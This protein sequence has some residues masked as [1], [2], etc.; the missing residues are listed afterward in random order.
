V[1]EQ[2]ALACDLACET[3]GAFGMSR[4]PWSRCCFHCTRPARRRDAHRY[5][6]TARLL[7][8][9]LTKNRHSQAWLAVICQCSEE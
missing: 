5:L 7:L 4:R 3:Y 6:Y 2:C 1:L 8:A 9:S